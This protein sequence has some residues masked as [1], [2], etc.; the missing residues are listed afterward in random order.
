[1]TQIVTT[2]TALSNAH[3]M[4][5][6][7]ELELSVTTSTNALLHKCQYY[8]TATKMHTVETFHPASIAPVTQDKGLELLFFRR[9]K[10]KMRSLFKVTLEM[11]LSASI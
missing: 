6:T 4:T 3:V 1:M 8:T 11:E 9:D 7:T 5:A 2:S 10:Q